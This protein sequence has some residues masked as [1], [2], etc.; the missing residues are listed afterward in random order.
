M[1]QWQPV[2]QVVQELGRALLQQWPPDTVLGK[3]GRGDEL[4]L[5]S[6]L[7]VEVAAQFWPARTVRQMNRG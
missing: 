2:M 7:I 3:A 6:S 5:D 1:R 4:G